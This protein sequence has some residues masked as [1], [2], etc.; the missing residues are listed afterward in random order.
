MKFSDAG[1]HP[2]DEEIDFMAQRAA[3]AFCTDYIGANRKLYKDDVVQI[4]KDSL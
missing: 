1:L 3:T 2:T 4:Y